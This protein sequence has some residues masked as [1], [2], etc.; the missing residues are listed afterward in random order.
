MMVTCPKCKFTQPKDRYCA[1]C[2]VDMDHY[3]PIK[4]PALKRFWNNPWTQVGIML[5]LLTITVN[6]LLV[7]NNVPQL[8]KE[9]LGDEQTVAETETIEAPEPEPT[10]P[11]QF[12]KTKTATQ[13]S[14]PQPVEASN[15]PKAAATAPIEKPKVVTA[16][17]NLQIIFAEISNDAVSELQNRATQNNGTVLVIDS[18]EPI[19]G[20]LGGLQG[21]DTLPGRKSGS[22]TPGNTNFFNFPVVFNEE[23]HGVALE[24][25]P[26]EFNSTDNQI[27]I[28]FNFR[29]SLPSSE[30][31]GVSSLQASYEDEIAVKSG[32]IILVLDVLTSGRLMAE[33]EQSQLSATP[34]NILSS[35]EF[36][37]GESV[38]GLFIQAL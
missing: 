33:T 6:Y 24:I 32:S 5:V 23:E 1:N 28:A 4:E 36:Q 25:T 11:A 21:I 15:Q 37:N 20:V 22:I 14:Q 35:Q 31:A 26:G 30:A 34:L 38:F 2:G 13:P 16:P 9:M 8:A 27:N 29:A 3:T 19:S 18:T 10:A 17:K 7:Q 12:N